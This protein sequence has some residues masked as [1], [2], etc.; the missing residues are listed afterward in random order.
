MSPK[1]LGLVCEVPPS[2]EET[3]APDPVPQVRS[4]EAGPKLS[5]QPWGR[6]HWDSAI[7]TGS[8]TGNATIT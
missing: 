1:L 3:R 4:L 8:G 2:R 5:Y 6:T 7:G